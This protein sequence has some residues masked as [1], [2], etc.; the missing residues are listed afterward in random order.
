ML[1]YGVLLLSILATRTKADTSMYETVNT[2]RPT[3]EGDATHLNKDKCL[4][5]A[6]LLSVTMTVGTAG[7]SNQAGCSTNIDSTKVNW[8][9]APE[10]GNV[11]ENCGYLWGLNPDTNPYLC[12]V[13]KDGETCASITGNY[14]VVN[15]GAPQK[16]L[17]KEQCEHYAN[18]LSIPMNEL[19][20]GSPPDGCS[21]NSAGTA[22]N[23]ATDYPGGS[24]DCTADNQCVECASGASCYPPT[25]FP[26]VYQATDPGASLTDAQINVFKD[27]RGLC[28]STTQYRALS[29]DG[30]LL[31]CKDCGTAAFLTEFTSERTTGT[32]KHG[33]CCTNT[34]HKVCKAMMA[35]YKAKCDGADKGV[36]A[37]CSS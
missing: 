30:N 33:K 6:R 10:D 23:W 9:P 26:D 32:Y 5:Y 11:N 3:S 28:S 14:E 31:E 21:V 27:S 19:S 8:N 1:K 13:C 18:L 24:A 12:V 22:A 35:E 16:T 36:S 2:G 4:E 37:T 29:S 20:N 7:T 34:H 17:T 15:S 25:V